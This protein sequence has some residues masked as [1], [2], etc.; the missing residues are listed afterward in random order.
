MTLLENEWAEVYFVIINS[1]GEMQLLAKLEGCGEIRFSGQN[2][3]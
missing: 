1:L 2:S 3:K